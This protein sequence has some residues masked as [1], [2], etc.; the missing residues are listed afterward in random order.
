MGA[1][2]ACSCG[3]CLLV[4]ARE[5]CNLDFRVIEVKDTVGCNLGSC[6]L[7]SALRLT[8]YPD[9]TVGVA[10]LGS[11]EEGGDEVAVGKLNDCSAVTFWERCVFIKEFIVQNTLAL[12]AERWVNLD[13]EVIDT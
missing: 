12:V 11:A 1:D 5:T 4:D 13:V 6:P 10:L 8:T 2:R 7:G 3:S 9:Y